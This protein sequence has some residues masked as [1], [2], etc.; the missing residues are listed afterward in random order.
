LKA[1][2]LILFLT[3]T[4]ML[5]SQTTKKPV[6]KKPVSSLVLVDTSKNSLEK[7]LEEFVKDEDLK[8][9]SFSFLAKDTKTGTIIAEYNP[10]MSLTP[11]STMKVVTTAAAM[12]ILGG[13]F[14]FKT[15]LQ[16]SGYIDTS[17]VLHGDIYI[18]GG[19]DPTLGSR[20][21]KDHYYE[22]DFLGVWANEIRNAGID[23]IAGRIIGDADLLGQ[24]PTPTTWIYGDLGNY[25]G[26]PPNGLTI[27][28]NTCYFE[29]Q[30]GSN[31]GDSTNIICVEPT[32][33]GMEIENTVK[34]A[35]SLDDNS[36]IIGPPY[37]FNRYIRGTIPK[38]QDSYE[39]RGSIPDPA[40]QTAFELQMALHNL[41]IAVNEGITTTRE[42][43]LNERYCDAARKE[44]YIQYSPSTSSI[45]YFINMNSVNLFAEHLCIQIGLTK[46]GSASTASGCA[47]IAEF[48]R[49]RGID[50][51]GLYQF[52]GSGLSRHNA[53]SARHLTDIMAYM[54][55]SKN[56]SGFENTLPVAGKSGTLSNVGKK[57]ILA[58]N[59]KAKSGTMQR[60]KSYSGY[61]KTKSGKKLAFAMIINNFN[62]PVK[63]MVNKFEKLMIAMA[64]FNE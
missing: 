34:S 32:I 3:Y 18:K 53:I 4:G 26:A 14:K 55:R 7:F 1:I 31:N 39:V 23:S 19:G 43:R 20:F 17:C 40:L 11:A 21:F 24:D 33:P 50:T 5:F 28:D 27:F 41:G 10:D 51:D 8:N 36:V 47:A 25:Y 45:I 35:T 30:S 58:G 61:V 52:D 22:P 37:R 64:S 62:C 9:A 42:L 46:Y 49:K 16:Y 60:V 54:S 13:G 6:V 15:T 63:T 29:F 2:Y 44:L 59:L 38:N 48:W 57:T 56:A 12:E